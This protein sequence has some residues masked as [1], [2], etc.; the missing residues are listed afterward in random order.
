MM[1]FGKIH[2]FIKFSKAFQK[3]QKKES[4]LGGGYLMHLCQGGK[5]NP[6][7]PRL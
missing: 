5:N 4:Q 3:G 1:Q 6:R 2:M 7:Y